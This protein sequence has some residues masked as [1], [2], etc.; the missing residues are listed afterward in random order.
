MSVKLRT[1]DNQFVRIPNE[2][3]VKSTVINITRFPIRRVDVRIGVAYREDPERVREVLLD[4]ARKNPIA[5]V[6]PEPL[7]IFDAFADS[8]LNLLFAVWAT[9]DNWLEL[10]NSIQEEVKER[11][12]EE[13]IEIPFPHRTL[14]VGSESEA[15][16]IRLVPDESR[17]PVDGRGPA[18]HDA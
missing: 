7:V 17:A 10:K 1:F 3:L 14:Y 4:V 15:F 9:R 2:T 18:A 11:F 16:P 12:D 8:S 5:L 6:E 13:G